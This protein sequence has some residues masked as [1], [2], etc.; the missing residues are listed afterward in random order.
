MSNTDLPLYAAAEKF[1]LFGF[2]IW[3]DREKLEQL[4][5]APA[6]RPINPEKASFAADEFF[7]LA[8]PDGYSKMNIKHLSPDLQILFFHIIHY[9]AAAG[10][11]KY[12]AEGTNG[13]IH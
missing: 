3:L 5:S 1:T 2:E 9:L 8:F 11:F 13:Q 6:T 10:I 12:P 4:R 7:R